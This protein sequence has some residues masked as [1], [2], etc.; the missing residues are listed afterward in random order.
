MVVKKV[1]YRVFSGSLCS[2]PASPARLVSNVVVLGS[3]SL[4]LDVVRAYGARDREACASAVEQLC[5]RFEGFLGRAGFRDY[6]TLSPDDFSVKNICASVTI[7]ASGGGG[8][9]PAALT[10][11]FLAD[12]MHRAGLYTRRPRQ[13]SSSASSAEF[14]ALCISAV[15]LQDTSTT[16][17]GSKHKGHGNCMLS[18]KPRTRCFTGRIQGCSSLDNMRAL[19]DKVSQAVGLPPAAS[20][21][22]FDRCVRL[23]NAVL[24]AKAFPAGHEAAKLPA[25]LFQQVRDVPVPAD[26]STAVGGRISGSFCI[27]NVLEVVTEGA[28]V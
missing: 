24:S 28:G 17:K 25:S 5:R 1:T 2:A 8:E 13:A 19:F 27:G 6:F 22:N 12:A 14:R 11:D 26:G 18:Y 16:P 23:T 20:V 7:P 3:S 9:D 4:V 15:P 21:A 10:P